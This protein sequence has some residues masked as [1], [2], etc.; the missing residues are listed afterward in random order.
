MAVTEAAV[1]KVISQLDGQGRWVSTYDGVRLVGQAKM[2]VGAEY[3][4]SEVFSK[5]LKLLSELIRQKR[6]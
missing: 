3:L 2:A 4:S 6:N 1:R 5:N